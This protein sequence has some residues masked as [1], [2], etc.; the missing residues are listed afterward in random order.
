MRQPAPSAP[1]TGPYARFLGW[2]APA[3][4]LAVIL[5]FV[6]VQH[7]KPLVE[8]PDPDDPQQVAMGARVYE[9]NCAACHGTDYLG[10]AATAGEAAVPP[11]GAG[12]EAGRL[13]AAAAMALI[14]GA[15]GASPHA[16]LD[17]LRAQRN[18]LQAFLADLWRAGASR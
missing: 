2:F 11:L 18:Y 14:A 10:R 12:S 16:D 17:L 7:V 3:L 4:G 9:R 5:A 8:G 13:G 1:A 6:Y 15:D